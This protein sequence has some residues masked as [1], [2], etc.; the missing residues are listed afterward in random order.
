MFRL[1]A[2]IPKG[3]DPVAEAFRKHVEAEGLK[4]VKDVSEAVDQ[5]KEAGKIFDSHK[6][7]ITPSVPLTLLGGTKGD[8]VILMSKPCTIKV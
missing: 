4:L 7:E 5:K 2:R 1:F 8:T 6:Q 3:L